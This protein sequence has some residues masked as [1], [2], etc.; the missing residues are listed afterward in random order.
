VHQRGLVFLPGG[1]V[2]GFAPNQPVP[3][4]DLLNVEGLR[5]RAWR[6]LPTPRKLAERIEEIALDLPEPPLEELFHAGETDIGTEDPRPEEASGPAT[7]LG[8]ASLAAGRGLMNLGNLLGMKG[9][10]NLGAKMIRGAVS[11]APR[12]SEAM[13]GRQEAALRAL[14]RDFQQGNLERALRR[15]LPFSDVGGRGGVPTSSPHLPDRNPMYSLRGILCGNDGPVGIWAGGEQDVWNELAKEYRKA[16]EQAARRGD[17]RRAAYIYGMLLRDYRLAANTLLQGGLAHDAAI[18][19][20]TKVGDSLAAARAFEAAGE[21]D[22]AVQLYRRNGDA[23]QAGD[24]LRRA[25]EEDA[26]LVEYRLAAETLVNSRQEYHTAG[27]LLVA[28]TGRVDLA[29]PYFQAGWAR[30]QGINILPGVVPC[31]L[32]LAELYAQE[33]SLTQLMMLAAEGDEFFRSPGK[34][35]EAG[36]FYNR[37]AQLA[38]RKNLA[39]VR[40]ELRDLALMGIAAKLRQR[41][42]A[43]ERPGHLV[44]TL[45]G[46][47]GAW[48]PAL[49]QD[50]QIALKRQPKPSGRPATDPNLLIPTIIKTQVGTDTVTAVCSARTSGD[51]FLGFASGAIVCFRPVTNQVVRLPIYCQPVTSLATDAEGQFLVVIQAGDTGPGHLASYGRSPDGSFR[52]HEMRPL[53]DAGSYWLT[54]VWRGEARDFIVGLCNGKDFCFLA[55]PLLNP[56]TLREWA[57][58]AAYLRCGLLLQEAQGTAMVCLFGQDEVWHSVPQWNDTSK[59]RLGWTPLLPP[60]NPL[61]SIPLA[62]SYRGNGVLE[63]AGL[64]EGGCL[65]WLLLNFRADTF[66]RFYE[67]KLSTHDGYLA[68]TLLRPDFLAGVRRSHIEWLRCSNNSSSRRWRVSPAL[69]PTN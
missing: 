49:V 44:G 59:E 37:L 54:S 30:R 53:E 20:L 7:A 63:I 33:E 39:A 51:V 34:E 13:L 31:G 2:L 18:I 40:D 12:L 6:A 8:S 15:A 68:A 64:G 23:V 35:N 17:Y 56:S 22:R 42:A 65:R 27:E 50:A 57:H 5:R 46:R 9:L 1:R 61:K 32:R 62:W 3:L 36:Q 14:L 26:A 24:L 60:G 58:D 66:V 55:D 4:S 38:D 11:L 47:S 52:I 25:G 41:A 67:T 21:V 29:L 10:A 43:E 69:R 19:Y 45:L 16:A 48:A 28:K